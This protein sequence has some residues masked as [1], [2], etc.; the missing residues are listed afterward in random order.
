MT[1]RKHVVRAVGC[2]AALGM[3]ATG[4][5]AFAN[6]STRS[7]SAGGVSMTAYVYIDN[8]SGWDNCGNF[9][10][11]ART[12]KVVSRLTNSV[13]WDPIGVG[14]SATIKGVG[15]SVSGNGGGSPTASITNSNATYAGIRGV[16]C[17]SWSTI[18]LGVYSTGRT[19]VGGTL[20]TVTAHV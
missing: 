9:N 6:E 3:L 12:S 14:A 2:A 15:V 16:A 1:I 18:Y 8:W 4:Q 17:A 13:E 10:T 19:T 7:G 20:L 5:P 11:S